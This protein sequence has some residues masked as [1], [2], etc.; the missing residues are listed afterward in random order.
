MSDAIANALVER[1]RILLAV[2]AVL[3]VFAIVPALRLELNRSLESLYADDD[4]LLVHYRESK[5][6]F[7]GDEF[8]IVAW[9]QPDL[10]DDEGKLNPEVA[11]GIRRFSDR[12]SRVGG[13][14]PASTQDLARVVENAVAFAK[15]AATERFG[16]KPLLRGIAG[17]F[18]LERQQDALNFSEGILVGAD[19]ETTAI[20]LRLKPEGGRDLPP[21][22]E[23][24]RR[25]RE[26][27]AAHNPPAYVAGEPVQVFDAFD[28]VER[29]GRTLFL[30]SLALLGGVL[31]I[32][33]RSFRWVAL[34]LLV[35][36]TTVLWTRAVL[37]ISGAELSM[38]S[39]ML[40]SIVTIVAVATVT[41]VAVRFRDRRRQ[42]EKVEALRRTITELAQPIFWTTATTAAGF[43]SL[44]ASDVMPVRSFGLMCAL[45]AGMVLVTTAMVVPGGAVGGVAWKARQPSLDSGARHPRLSNA[46]AHTTAFARRRSGAISLAAVSLT[47]LAVFGMSQMKIETDF[48]KN[49]RS[50][51]PIVVA[52]NFVE[53]GLGGAGTWEV[54]FP[55]PERL[56]TEHLARVRSLANQL[57]TVKVNGHEPLTKVIAVTDGLDLLPASMISDDPHKDLEQIS[58]LQPEFVTSLHNAE[59]GRMRILLRSRER[60]SAE[61]KREII[62]TV[63]ATARAEFPEANT[64]GLFVL[65]TYLI[66]SL[67]RDQAVSFSIAGGA[68]LVMMVVAFR[69]PTLALV[70]LVPNVLPILLLLGGMGLIGIPVNIG[71]AMIASVSIGLTIDSSIHYLTG[72][73]TARSAG[74]SVAAA[75]DETGRNV[76]VALVFATVA[77]CAGFSVLSASHFV[78][79]IYFGVLVSLAMLGGLLGNLLLLPALVP[80]VDRDVADGML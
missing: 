61:S 10:L 42:F 8:V 32:L 11:T 54:N 1:R 38:V 65:L 9:R 73:R 77:L 15:E 53:E 62:E 63:Q 34:P 39:S 25:I 6:L 27:A 33:F 48:S 17:R 16:D 26:I 36:L 79:L 52:L 78:P 47:V 55:A 12:L 28:Y 72:Y 60:Q 31:L 19:G 5:E 70:A 30:I 22:G 76:G 49:F 24:F 64:T 50:D 14:N 13:V 23:T 35:T 67:L 69:R 37:S 2:V 80:W 66:E 4:P 74:M 71:T 20:V 56:T 51:S 7:G 45:G 18:A 46:L 41:H 58:K 3:T 43:L 21:R 68:L 57:R 59:A 29:D 75:L 44:T 40:N